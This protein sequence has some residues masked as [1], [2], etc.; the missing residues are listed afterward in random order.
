MPFTDTPVLLFRKNLNILQSSKKLLVRFLLL[1]QSNQIH[2]SFTS[3]S[4][5][6]SKC[7]VRP[8][9]AIT[10]KEINRIKREGGEI[11]R[12]NTRKICY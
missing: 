8:S 12:E 2:Q 4:Y 5:C 10:K 11:K 3:L 9:Q 6:I 7:S 1:A